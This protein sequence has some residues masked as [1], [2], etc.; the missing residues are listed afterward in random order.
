MTKYD[1]TDTEDLRLRNSITLPG[2]RSSLYEYLSGLPLEDLQAYPKKGYHWWMGRTAR[3]V[4]ALA[5]RDYILHWR[6]FA[7]RFRQQYPRWYLEALT[8]DEL[9]LFLLIYLK[10][11][12]LWAYEGPVHDA[13]MLLDRQGKLFRKTPD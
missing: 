7:L 6:L 12:P 11:T 9:R 5:L 13:V 2:K 10:K 3:S 4:Q 8:P 1:L